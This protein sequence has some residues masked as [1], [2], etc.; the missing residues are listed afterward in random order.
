MTTFCDHKYDGKTPLTEDC[1]CCLLKRGKAAGFLLAEA[2][3]T[4]VRLKL[5]RKPTTTHGGIKFGSG[6]GT[7]S[8]SGEQ[9]D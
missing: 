4:E 1:D 7:Y 9:L 8:M 3:R 5:G 6:W 2:E